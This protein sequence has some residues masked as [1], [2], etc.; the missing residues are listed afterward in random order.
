MCLQDIK[1][2]LNVFM[3]HYNVIDSLED[4]TGLLLSLLEL[5]EFEPS[6]LT[7][8]IY[9][10]T[11]KYGLVHHQSQRAFEFFSL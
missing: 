1:S 6:S 2:H 3:V 9:V 8:L 5:L 11:N 7:K 10:F 4:N